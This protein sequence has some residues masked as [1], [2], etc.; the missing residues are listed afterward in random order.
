MGERLAVKSGHVSSADK[1]KVPYII[2]RVALIAFVLLMFF[3]SAS[4][5]RFVV[6]AGQASAGTTSSL[7]TNCVSYRSLVSG[8]ERAFNKGWLE[9]SY[10][11]LLFACCVLT[12]LGM[13]SA[14]V[15]GCMSLGNLRM[16]NVGNR[17]LLCGGVALVLSTLGIVG[18]YYLITGSA[19]TDR[20]TLQMPV[21][22]W[23]FA[24]MACIYGICAA[25]VFFVTPK[26]EK[27][28][29]MEMEPKFQLFLMLMP[30]LALVFAFSYL[31]L[32]SWRYAFY[33]YKA[34]GTIG[35]DNFVGFKWFKL[36]VQNKAYVTRLLRVLKN[37]LAMSGL[38]ILTSWVPMAF[39]I[40]L[41]E[42]RSSK[43]KRVVQTCT[44][45]PNFISWVLVYAIAFAI[46]NTDGFINTLLT[47]ITGN[48]HNTA[49]LNDASH[50]WL[51]MLLWGMWKGTG[52]S[53]IIYISGI[54]GIDQQ[55]YEAATVDGAG[56]FQ[57]M[58]HITVPGLL[59]TYVVML[60]MSIAGI[61][62][63]G[64]DQYLV[65][66]NA[67]NKDFLEVLDL[68]V[69]NLGIGES[70]Q[71]PLSTVVGMTKSLISVALLFV[72]NTASKWIR[73]SS[74]V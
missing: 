8:L 5:T 58:W 23:L 21:G 53:A 49:Y 55:L 30:F 17:F 40:L 13:I 1:C 32:F 72:A 48:S 39:A 54:A 16:K 43:F 28:M 33:D 22:M 61:L 15:G 47:N 29:K 20:V 2:V 10:F 38:G 35:K 26:A 59:P 25:I 63:N 56:R 69:Y 64:M 60:V 11:Y 68:Y 27:S 4:P 41:T 71:I 24:G 74:V 66:T 67:N 50:M 42:V 31:P 46:F 18:C 3:P 9:Q 70:S 52:W 14:A 51:K 44:T 45:I 36:L 19:N 57:K 6:S 65:F 73:G 7:F 34:G 37:T 12:L 62:S